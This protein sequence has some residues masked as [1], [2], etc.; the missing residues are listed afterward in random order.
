[1]D[2][3]LLV[4]FVNCG[5]NLIEDVG[6]PFEW[7]TLFIRQHIAEGAAVEILHH[8]IRNWARFHARK[9]KIGYVNNVRMAQTTGGAR[10]PL[11]ALDKFVVA[12]E[13]RRDEF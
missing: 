2:D 4:R 7:Q 5:T 10:L 1:M 13:L 12:H 3:A 6:Y 8:E 11:E 9:T